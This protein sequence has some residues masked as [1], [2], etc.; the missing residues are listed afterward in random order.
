MFCEL[1]KV[2]NCIVGEEKVRI[3]IEFRIYR[4]KKDFLQKWARLAKPSTGVDRIGHKISSEMGKIGQTFY[5][6]QDRSI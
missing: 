2:C 1:A 6:W 4:N 5:S 3:P